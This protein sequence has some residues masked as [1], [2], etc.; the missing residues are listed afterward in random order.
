MV[1]MLNIDNNMSD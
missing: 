1:P